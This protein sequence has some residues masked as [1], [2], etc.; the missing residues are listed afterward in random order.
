MLIIQ[1]WGGDV[2]E[3]K[4]E[5]AETELESSIKHLISAVLNKQEWRGANRTKKNCLTTVPIQQHS[6]LIQLR[7]H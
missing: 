7:A 2:R 3:E 5:R 6:I 4:T 1:E